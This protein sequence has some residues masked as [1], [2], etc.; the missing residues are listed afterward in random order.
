MA[1][2]IA[3]ITIL[4]YR[5]SQPTK[6]FVT[7]MLEPMTGLF[8]NSRLLI[9]DFSQIP[10]D[11]LPE[12]NIQK[13]FEECKAQGQ[14]PRLPAN[15]QRFNDRLLEKLD[16]RY[17]VSRYGED[18]IAMLEGSSIAKDRRTI[19]LGIDI[20]ASNQEI[21]YAPCD[22]KIVRTNEESENHSFG[23]FLIFKPNDNSVPYILFG[24]LAANPRQPGTVYAGE[25]IAK[26]GDYINHENGG[27]SRH[28]HLQMLTELPPADQAPPGYGL[29]DVFT[30]ELQQQFPDPM[31]Y[32]P[33]W[34]IGA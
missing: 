7:T 30:Q 6:I 9:L 2:K 15:R 27:W 33:E 32:F 11:A 34:H 3:N 31:P 28:L 18:R 13:Y 5:T 22:G 23:H 25:P 4:R 20:F 19:H 10:T 21:V 14:D 12:E 8:N 24:H 1:K 29:M 17:L 26:L 16:V